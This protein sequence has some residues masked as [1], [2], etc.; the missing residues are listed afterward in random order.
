MSLNHIDKKSKIGLL[1]G[2]LSSE[3]EVSLKTGTAIF[4]ALVSLGYNVT[5]IDPKDE[6][7]IDLI[8]ESDV[9]FN[10]LH[11]RYGEDGIIQGLLES[12][13][14]PYTGSPVVSSSITMNKVFTKEILAFYNIPI[15]PFF[16]LSTLKD[17]DNL[18]IDLPL[19]V[20]PANE[21][22]S[23]GI[24]LVK[25]KEQLL[26]V[27]KESLGIYGELLIEPYIKGKEVQVAV[28]NGEVLGA[29]EIRPKREF[30]DYE[31]KYISHDT[32]YILPA[33]ISDDMLDLLF[34][35]SKNINKILK[36]S[37]VIRID[38]IVTDKEVLLLEVNTLP[39]M[40][41]SSLVPKIANYKGLSFEKL[42]EDILLNAKIHGV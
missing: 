30:Y 23:V 18:K 22:S 8:K 14:I 36:C 2:G 10:A 7:F 15:I 29:I 12:L 21:G 39:G 34:N 5:K 13:K 31:A 28:L 6:N 35:Y 11:G 16:E 19:V 40:T 3:R 9:I 25:N 26:D 37:G 20:K 33:E 27:T 41:E 38:Y 32:E 42:C 4:N 17:M 1:I 24:T